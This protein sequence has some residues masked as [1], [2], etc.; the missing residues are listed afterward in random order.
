VKGERKVYYNGKWHKTTIYDM[1]QLRPG[2]EIE[3]I[4]VI[5][6]PASTL[7][8]PPGRHIRMDEWTLIWLT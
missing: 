2:N 1:D 7:F 6:A 8:L 3:G 5:E 4:A